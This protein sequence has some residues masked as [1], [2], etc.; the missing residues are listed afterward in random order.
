VTRDVPENLKGRIVLQEQLSRQLLAEDRSFVYSRV[1]AF[2]VACDA[3]ANQAAS[4]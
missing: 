3:E 4:A 1:Q 2:V